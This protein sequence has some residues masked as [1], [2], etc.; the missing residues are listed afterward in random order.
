MAVFLPFLRTFQYALLNITHRRIYTLMIFLRGKKFQILLFRY[1]YID[2]EAVGIQPRFIHQFTT[3]TGNTFQMDI[4]IET[5]H[6]A[7]VLGHTHQAF[8]GII[9]TPHHTTAQKQS[10]YIIAAIELHRQIY[11]L[12]DRKRSTRQIIRATIDAICTVIDAIVRQHHF[13]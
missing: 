6:C 11:Q 3:G 2:A 13:Q 7:Q 8:H 9:R 12:A 10:F 4:S 1:F 5:M